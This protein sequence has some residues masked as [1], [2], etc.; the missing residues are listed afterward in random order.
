MMMMVILVVDDSA[1]P[2]AGTRLWNSLMHDVASGPTLNVFWK[3]PKTTAI[4]TYFPS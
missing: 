3:C 2:V 4:F 1:F